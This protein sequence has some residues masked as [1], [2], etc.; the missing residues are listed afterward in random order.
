M[1]EIEN[2][3]HCV[4]VGVELDLYY[5]IKNIKADDRCDFE[6][7]QAN[8]KEAIKDFIQSY[9][10]VYTKISVEEIKEIVR[11]KLTKILDGLES[12]FEEEQ[13]E[14]WKGGSQELSFLFVY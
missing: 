6:T 1:E 7:K 8:K 11:V 2:Q 9:S 5:K 13:D 3:K 10:K 12:G 14:R 4:S